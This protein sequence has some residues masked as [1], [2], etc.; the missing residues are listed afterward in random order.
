MLTN[1]FIARM[2]K[3]IR[4]WVWIGRRPASAAPMATP[5]MPSSASGVSKTRSSPYLSWR[6]RVVPHIPLASSMPW[7][8]TMTRGSA[9]ISWSIASRIA[10]LHLIT[11]SMAAV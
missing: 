8:S 2:R 7:P 5:V 1:W 9:A 6:P 3:S 4:M 11:R 10:S